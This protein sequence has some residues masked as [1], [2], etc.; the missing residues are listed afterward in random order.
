MIFSYKVRLALLDMYLQLF[1]HPITPSTFPVRKK[2]LRPKISLH[3]PA[4]VM[5]TA[6]ARAQE[7][8]AHTMLLDGPI[9]A[10]MVKRIAAG[11]AKENKQA[12]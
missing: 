6:L 1:A 9:S 8:A 11:R 3:L 2:F 4:T 5:T 7:V 10:S 12:S